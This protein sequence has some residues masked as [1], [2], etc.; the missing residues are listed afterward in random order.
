MDFKVV[1]SI[2]FL[3]SLITELR[4]TKVH[5]RIQKHD[6]GFLP[7]SFRLSTMSWMCNLTFKCFSSFLNP[8]RSWKA[9]STVADC[10]FI[11][12]S[13]CWERILADDFASKNNSPTS[14]MSSLAIT[15]RPF[16]L[17]VSADGVNSWTAYLKK[18]IPRSMSWTVLTSTHTKIRYFSAVNCPYH[19][20]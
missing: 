16:T 12:L 6:Q 9:A 17:A 18:K 14:W 1:H 5:L 11:Y 4:N 7:F 20:Q 8:L 3:W 15:D 10:H 13:L 19:Y 2:N